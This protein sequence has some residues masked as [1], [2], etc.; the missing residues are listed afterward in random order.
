MNMEGVLMSELSYSSTLNFCGSCVE[1]ICFRSE[2]HASA[3][4]ITAE[5]EEFCCC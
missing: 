2:L 4:D 5:V 3:A 1:K